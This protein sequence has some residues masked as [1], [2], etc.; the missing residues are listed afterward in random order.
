VVLA[1]LSLANISA[2]WPGIFGWTKPV[3]KELDHNGV[4]AGGTRGESDKAQCEAC[5]G[6]QVEHR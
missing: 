5:D 4:N 2:H 6:K 3:D 1:A